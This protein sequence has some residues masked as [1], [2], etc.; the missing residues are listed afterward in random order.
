MERIHND[1]NPKRKKKKKHSPP[2][3]HYLFR[4]I[5][6][7]LNFYTGIHVVGFF[8]VLF[9][10][11]FFRFSHV[12]H[13]RRTRNREKKKSQNEIAAPSILFVISWCM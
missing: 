6:Y 8:G 12:H 11:L 7:E 9:S 3:G 10:F 13:L 4:P 1:P 2:E 5:G